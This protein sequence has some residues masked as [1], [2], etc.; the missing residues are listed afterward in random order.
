MSITITV[1]RGQTHFNTGETISGQISWELEKDPKKVTLNLFWYTAGKGSQDVGVVDSLV[2]DTLNRSDSM[3]FSFQLPEEPYSYSGKLIS[4]CWALEA[5]V[6]KG[7]DKD[8][9][10]LVVAPEGYEICL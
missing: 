5:F 6:K 2:I 9:Y 8:Q 4:I 3:A 1:D 10:E 7:K